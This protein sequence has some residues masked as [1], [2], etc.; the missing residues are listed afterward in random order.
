M[1]S[2][3]DLEKFSRKIGKMIG[4]GIPLVATLDLLAREESDSDLAPVLK[5]VVSQLNSNNPFVIWYG[6]PQEINHRLS[7]QSLSKPVSS[8]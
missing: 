1:L 6:F 5:Q 4:S 7:F 2:A 3:K 8:R